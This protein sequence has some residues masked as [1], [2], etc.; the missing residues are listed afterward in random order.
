MKRSQKPSHPNLSPLDL[1]LLK[2]AVVL[3]NRQRVVRLAWEALGSP[4][5]FRG[6]QLDRLVVRLVAS[7]TS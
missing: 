6:S 5:S 3:L 4:G 2:Q 7:R 1:A